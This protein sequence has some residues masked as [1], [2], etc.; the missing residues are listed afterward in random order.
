[1]AVLNFEEAVLMLN[2]SFEGYFMYRKQM[3]W[4]RFFMVAVVLPVIWLIIL[5]PLCS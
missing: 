5:Q 1:M 2:F 4:C 3:C